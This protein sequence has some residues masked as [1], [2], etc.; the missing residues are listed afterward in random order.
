MTDYKEEQ[1][2]EMEALESIYP[3][4]IQVLETEPYQSFQILVHSDE[5]YR[6]DPVN[7]ILGFT[8]TE[9]YPDEGPVMEIKSYENIEEKHADELMDLMKEQVEENLGMVMIFTLISA[10]QEQLHVIAQRIKD[11]QD[12]ETE[13]KEQEH[14][15]EEQ[16][17]FEG[18][19]V[20]IENFLNWKAKF[21]A[22]LE[23]ERKKK[24][25]KAKDKTKLTG[26]MLFLT[27][28]T[29]DDSDMKFLEDEG[30]RVDVD[31]SLFQDL[32][33]LDLDED[34]DLET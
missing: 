5:V 4:E 15:E 8:Y 11:A 13:R 27:D 7:V 20:N 2:N 24:G 3:D 33:D 25:I 14:E 30:D 34:L 9:T 32:E 28:N 18:I 21:D 6:G 31:E 29:L 10:V 16:R 17:K 19:R 26:K 23:E 22:E 1:D 12:E